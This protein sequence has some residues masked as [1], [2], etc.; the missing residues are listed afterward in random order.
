MT[1]LAVLAVLAAAL[2]AALVVAG[3]W[4]CFRLIFAAIDRAT[5]FPAPAPRGRHRMPKQ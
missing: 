1:V 3:L 4:S 5:T 2:L